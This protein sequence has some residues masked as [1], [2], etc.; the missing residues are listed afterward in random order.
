MI[1]AVHRANALMAR[2][3]PATAG[4]S[5]AGLLLSRT[6]VNYDQEQTMGT[7]WLRALAAFAGLGLMICASAA[8]GQKQD[9]DDQSF[10]QMRLTDKQVKGFISAQKQLAPLTSKL[11][12]QGEKSDPALQK[13]V[14]QIAKTNGFTSLEELGDVTSNISIV[15]A[16]LD[17]KTGQFTEPPDLIRKEMEEVKQDTQMSQKDKDQALSEMQKALKVAAPLQY[18]ENISVVKKYQKELEQVM[19]PEADE[20]GGAN[21]K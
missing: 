13:Q 8:Q 2:A 14:E 3:S 19:A 18:K 10:K 6:E 4:T 20:Q 11:E 16:G 15:L 1:P 21:K 9:P 12:A 7:T 5:L 17:P